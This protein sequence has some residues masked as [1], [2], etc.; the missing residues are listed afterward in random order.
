MLERRSKNMNSKTDNTVIKTIS[1]DQEL[2]EQDYKNM[3]NVFSKKLLQ[4]NEKCVVV[5]FDDYSD[6]T[7]LPG[8]SIPR[9]C[10][11]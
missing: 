3:R 9:T 7:K 5:A 4:E 8:D 11:G 2:I 6:Y 1:F 10:M